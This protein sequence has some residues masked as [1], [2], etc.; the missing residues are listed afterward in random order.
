L[1]LDTRATLLL[2][3][4]MACEL[5]PTAKN[6]TKGQQR[7]RCAE[8]ARITRRNSYDRRPLASRVSAHWTMLR[9]LAPKRGIA[10]DLTLDQY[11]T[12]VALPCAYSSKGKPQAN[13]IGID[14]KDSA[15]G[16]TVE[17]SVPCCW[18][19]NMLKSNVL[20]HDQCLDAANR[21]G[22]ACGDA[23]RYR[24]KLPR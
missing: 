23:P 18:R 24:T 21:Y 7:P 3:L 15:L 4:V 22:I 16:Y 10:F 12:I 1:A 11:R 19:H 20:T 13:H 6:Y 5:H 17:N 2:L 14:R 9:H 8:C